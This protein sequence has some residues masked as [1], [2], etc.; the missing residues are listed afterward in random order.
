MSLRDKYFVAML[1]MSK[2][3]HKSASVT[4]GDRAEGVKP[5]F[6]L[7]PSTPESILLITV[8]RP[9]FSIPV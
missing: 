4:L 3:R 2:M 1:Q 6:R 9:A 8:I 7:R 5:R